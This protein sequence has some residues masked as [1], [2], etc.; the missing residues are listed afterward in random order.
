VGQLGKLKW[1]QHLETRLGSKAM[2]REMPQLSSFTIDGHVVG[3]P[4]DASF[5]V[6]IVNK[7][8]LAS[9][10]LTGSVK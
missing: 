1:F 5:T 8:T 2:A 9:G 6:A 4:Y 10:I 7:K 3:I